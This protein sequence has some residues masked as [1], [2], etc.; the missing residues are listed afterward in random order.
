MSHQN[1]DFKNVLAEE[2]PFSKS[3]ATNFM[4]KIYSEYAGGDRTATFISCIN[5][6]HFVPGIW[7]ED[8][9]YALLTA[10]F[11]DDRKKSVRQ[12]FLSCLE[13]ELDWV[14]V[15]AD[16]PVQPGTVKILSHAWNCIANPQGAPVVALGAWLKETGFKIYRWQER[17][18]HYESGQ[19]KVMEDGELRRILQRDFALATYAENDKQKRVYPTSNT[20][21]E[22]EISLGTMVHRKSTLPPV[23]GLSFRNGVLDIKTQVLHPHTDAEFR[24][25]QISADYYPGAKC[26]SWEAFVASSLPDTEQAMLMQEICGYLLAGRQDEQKIFGFWGLPRSGK[27]TI[28][29][30]LGALMGTKSIVSPS[31]SSLTG[32]FGLAAAKDASII[33]IGEARFDRDNKSAIDILLRISGRDVVEVNV[34]NRDAFQATL[35]GRIVMV[36]NE[37]PN[38]LE[39]SGALASRFVHVAFNVSFLDNEDKSL[40][41]RLLSELPGI[42]LWCLEGLRRLD[43]RGKFPKTAEHERMAKIQNHTSNHF[44]MWYRDCVIADGDHSETADAVRASYLDWCDFHDVEENIRLGVERL[45]R[46]LTARGHATSRAS[47]N[48]VTGKQPTTKLGMRLAEAGGAVQGSFR[49]VQGCSGLDK[50]LTSEFI[51]IQ[52]SSETTENLSTPLLAETDLP[53]TMNNPEHAGQGLANYERTLNRNPEQSPVDFTWAELDL[54]DYATLVRTRALAA[55]LAGQDHGAAYEEILQELITTPPFTPT[56]E[57]DE[58]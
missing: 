8:E 34:K 22:L 43:T 51:V 37:Q 4:A 2:R 28:L 9:A 20:V 44:V 38:V 26:P 30:V 35:P 58:S 49:V 56:T 36:S 45:G 54:P 52:G 29:R 5:L 17:F 23:G 18:Y 48:K 10:H 11:P 3:H 25:A 1:H 47:K 46:T 55:E 13:K 33:Q 40:E 24:I 21:R 39:D 53:R 15:D 19:Y 7:T 50:P 41:S 42:A 14:A 32:S 16:A 12:C 57:T 27:S 6:A 31:L